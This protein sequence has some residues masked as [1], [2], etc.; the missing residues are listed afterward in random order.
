MLALVRE[1]QLE[2]AAVHLRHEPRRDVGEQD[3]Y[4]NSTV[5]SID[6]VMVG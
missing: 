5:R 6:S 2:T 3:T 4:V 1:E